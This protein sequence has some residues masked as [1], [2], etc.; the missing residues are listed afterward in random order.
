LALLISASIVI[1]AFAITRSYV[2]GGYSCS[3]TFTCTSTQGKTVTYYAGNY[4]DL[5]AWVDLTLDAAPWSVHA[6]KEIGL[7]HSVTAT[8][9]ADGRPVLNAICRSRVVN[10]LDTS[11]YWDCQVAVKP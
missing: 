5:Y 3:G 4:G 11:D 8:A 10:L 1:P 6:Y 2:V 7:V 9:N